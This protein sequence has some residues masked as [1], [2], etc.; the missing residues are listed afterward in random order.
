MEKKTNNL[1]SFTLVRGAVLDIHRCW[2]DVAFNGVAQPEEIVRYRC[3]EELNELIAATESGADDQVLAELIDVLVTFYQL[4]LVVGYQHQGFIE[5]AYEAGYQMF[6]MS[7]VDMSFN[8]K[9]FGVSSLLLN[10]KS[11]LSLAIF[12]MFEYQYTRKLA[13]DHVFSVKDLYMAMDGISASNWSKFPE[14]GSVDPDAECMYI[15]EA[16][17]GRYHD[18]K[19]R[20]STNTESGKPVY[21]FYEASGKV[22]KPSTFRKA[23]LSA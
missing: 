22:V 20:V 13:S 10:S 21:V 14:V 2:V 12:L 6:V 3:D 8:E 17:A 16:N 15:E 18:V 9:L 23:D 4:E 1:L 19:Y 5:R 11:P 7:S